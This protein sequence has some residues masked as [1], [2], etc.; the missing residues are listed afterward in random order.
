MAY[1]ITNTDGTLSYSVE[2]GKINTSQFSLALIGRNV[3]NYG[4]YFAQN[5]I[6]QLENFAG[7]TAPAPGTRLIGQLWF[8]KGESLLRV[9]DGSDWK[10]TGVVVASQRTQGRPAEGEGAGTQFFNLDTNKLEIHNGTAFVEASYPG[11]VTTAYSN[12]SANGSPAHFGARLRTL[13]LK[14]DSGFTWP[15]I[16]L[17]YVKSGTGTN[18]GA[19]TVNGQ[20]ETI[21]T[22]FSDYEF[23]IA[24]DTATPVG[25]ETINY[26]SE[27]VG[28]G[29]I[30]AART[31]RTAGKVLKGV[32]SR[33][34]Y[35]ATNTSVF[36][37]IYVNTIGDASNPV[38]T[39]FV[40]N[41][42]VNT[43]LNIPG[44]ASVTG[45]LTVA[46]SIG[47]TGDLNATTST[48]RVA[49][50]EVSAGSIL[51][52]DTTINGNLTI[53]GVNT[54]SLGTDAEK[55][56]TI[57]GDT[58]DT[59]SLTV[60]GT[61]DI[62]TADV[63]NLTV[64][65]LTTLNE[66][67]A[68]GTSTFN[69]DINLGNETADTL[70]VEATSVFNGTTTFNDDIVLSNGVDLTISNGTLV[71]GGSSSISGAASNVF[72]TDDSANA[73]VH[74]IPFV[75]AATTGQRP[76]KGDTGLTY[77]PGQG[78]LGLTALTATGT[79]SFGSLTD[80]SI[81][82]TDFES[83][84]TSGAQKVPT[85]AAVKTYV[86]AQVTAQ[87]LDFQ[88]DSG[89]ALS[90]D[91]DS[92]VLDIAGGTNISTVGS[93]NQITVNLNS[94]LTG[95]TS[96]SAG[97]FTGDLTGDVDAATVSATGQ[98]SAGSFSTTGAVSAASVTATGQI[99]AGSFSGDLTG[100]VTGDVSGNAGT[101]T[102]TATNSS[103][104]TQ[105][106]LFS[107]ETSGD[108]TVRNDTSLSYVSS[109][110]T[111]TAGTFKGALENGTLNIS[112]AS[113]TGA[114]N[115][116]F[117]GTVQ[118]GTF[119]DGSATLTNGTLTGATSGS[120]SGTVTAGTFS[121][122]T[123]TMS[124]GTF[125]G[126][127]TSAKYA[128]LAEIY[129]ADQDYEPGTVVKLGGSAEITQTTS[130]NDM[131]VFGVIS[132]NP[133][134]LMNKDADGLPVALTGRVPVK[135]VGKV[136]KGD[137]LI[138]SDVPGVA[139]ALADEAYDARAII[140][141]SLQDKNDGDIGSVEAVIGVK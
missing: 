138:S 68:T 101:V 118:A 59:Q 104:T 102:V 131:E 132:T 69:G 3:S 77:N 115:G 117:S 67:T 91:L 81:T 128:D 63:T 82:I 48:I 71:L 97:S 30:L 35:E 121:D 125:S 27:L 46:G 56:E 9:W 139:W 1:E 123:A 140:G 23:T 32:N 53:N 8:D 62:A 45:D 41:L 47:L 42:T 116:T 119:T 120:F 37:S 107:T 28:S 135:V 64:Q 54:Q 78:S 5:T 108:A 33:Q 85:S 79:V 60:D 26:Y 19:T 136:K 29:G 130:H 25:E 127:A 113:I 24:S 57:F 94:A 18:T 34:E 96:V 10:R 16:A 13:F 129:A 86:D 20:K 21:M 4:Q 87:D 65:S 76:L 2:D 88:G 55:V 74:Y 52:G 134:Y 40:D 50:I 83:T 14:D 109:T 122:G 70:T 12:S 124:G 89:G 61:A 105:Y 43:L 99:S 90:I 66:I 7:V 17:V 22:I 92:E 84:L 106:I 36:D 114:V 103:A 38:Q 95:L 80:G 6:R 110:N 100:D 72:V 137:R 126:T 133:A 44:A 51:N 39:Q 31:G 49:N 141:R 98:I 11:E 93:G 73:T 75:D 112:S 111:L 15:V 58:I